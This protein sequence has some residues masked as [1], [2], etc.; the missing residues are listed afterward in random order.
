MQKLNNPL[1]YVRVTFEI[2]KIGEIDTMNEKYNAE[3]YIESK[4]FEDSSKLNNSTY[5]PQKNWNPKLFIENA[6][7]DLKEKIDYEINYETDGSCCV[8]EKRHVKG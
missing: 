8:I 3:Y 4:W 7:Q 5:D 6:Y 1:K 2:W